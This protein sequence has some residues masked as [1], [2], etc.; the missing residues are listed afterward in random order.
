MLLGTT[1]ARQKRI[2][3]CELHNQRMRSFAAHPQIVH[4]KFALIHRLCVFQHVHKVSEAGCGLWV[5]QSPQRVHEVVCRERRPLDQ[6][7]FLRKL[8]V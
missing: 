4:R 1:V 8:K 7:K 3:C 5:H 2:R 6:R